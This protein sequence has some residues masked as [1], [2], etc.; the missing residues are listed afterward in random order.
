MKFKNL[1]KQVPKEQKKQ[2]KKKE[3]LFCKFHEQNDVLYEISFTD[4]GIEFE[5]IN[6]K[7]C[8]MCGKLLK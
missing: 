4:I 7:Y 8:P 2:L 6:L 3:C 1:N 5:K